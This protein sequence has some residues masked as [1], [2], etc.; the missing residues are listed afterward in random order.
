MSPVIQDTDLGG[1]QTSFPHTRHSA[2][3]AARE[4]DAEA[5]RRALQTLME[6]YWKPV[7]K[8]IR[9]HWRAENEEAKDLTQGFLAELIERELLARF[10]PSRAALRT[11]IRLCVDGFVGNA[12]KAAN[13]LK[14]G[15]GRLPLSLEF[16]AAETEL[17]A[18]G[19]ACGDPDEF[20]RQEWTRDLFAAAVEDLK[21]ELLAKGKDTAFALFARYDLENA[22][23]DRVTYADLA[24]EF[25]LPVTQV[26]NELALARRRFRSHV[27]ARLGMMASNEEEFRDEA[28]RL[29]GEVPS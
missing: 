19:D 20:F 8:Y 15:G 24:R 1:P 10:D 14:R 23:S 25:D 9:R 4:G 18:G 5:R 27:L 11:Y 2:V 12:R 13:R 22:P 26:T 6:A 7:Y 21:R 29:F 17:V 3:V 28:R 16:D